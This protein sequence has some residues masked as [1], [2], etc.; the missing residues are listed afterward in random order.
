MVAYGAMAGL[1]I[2]LGLVLGGVLTEHASWRWVFLVN[3]PIGVALVAAAPRVLPE[4]RGVARRLDVP[5]A[6]LGTVAL[7]MLVFGVI[8]A[9]NHQWGEAWSTLA[10]VLAVPL[11]AAFVVVQRTAAE[12]TLPLHLLRHRARLGA[13]LVAALLFGCLYPCFFLLS[14]V[15]QGLHGHDPTGAGLRFLPIGAGVLAFAI[16]ARRQLE[17]VGARG[18]VLLGTVATT[19]GA[20]GLLLLD[21]DSAY[22]APLLP[23]LVGLGAGVGTTFVANASLAMTDVADSDTGVASGLL[24][25]FQAVG[26]SIGVAV[27]AS[28]AAASASDRVEALGA[29]PSLDAVRSAV[30]SGYHVGLA[31]AVGA[32]AA[33]VVVAFLTAPRGGADDARR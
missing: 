22:A 25:T 24:S 18:L 2:T 1:G 29:A 23:A 4:S 19:V 13:Y 31:V 14:Q 12:P 5:G 6:L 20:G 7:T 32:A 26:G 33:A 8:R 3:V 16:L 10:L 28:I 15:L 21:T 30:M 9:G 27:I 17:R 11:L